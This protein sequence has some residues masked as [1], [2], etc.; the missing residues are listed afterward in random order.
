MP[1]YAIGLE[2]YRQTDIPKRYHLSPIDEADFELEIW[3][4]NPKLFSE[5]ERVDPFSLYLSLRDTKDERVETA[6]EELMEK[7]KK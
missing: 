2:E 7:I 5:N 1:V 6:L 4:Y 3:N